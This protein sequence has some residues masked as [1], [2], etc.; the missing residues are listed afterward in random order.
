[1]R[2]RRRTICSTAVKSALHKVGLMDFR[3]M[4]L[5]L[6]VIKMKG[7]QRIYFVGCWVIFNVATEG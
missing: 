1:M 5:D 4:H 6:R 7:V 3:K 2:S